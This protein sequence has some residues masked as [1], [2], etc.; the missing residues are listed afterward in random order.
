MQLDA[1]RPGEGFVELAL[2]ASERAHARSF[3][4]LLA[5]TGADIRQGVDPLV[6]KRER[7]LQRLLAAHARYQMEKAGADEP[8]PDQAAL[9]ERLNSLKAEYEELQAQVR[10]E[11][12][13]YQNL[14]RPKALTIS[15]IQAQLGSDDFL[16]E[17]VLGEEQSYLCAVTATSVK[18]YKL[19]QKSKLD[20]AA[21]EVYK[22]LIARQMTGA[23]VD[24]KYQARVEDADNQYYNKALALSRMLLAPVA[25]VLGKKRL[26]IVTEGALQY[27]S[28]DSLPRPTANPVDAKT[29]PEIDESYLISDHEI[30]ILPS[31]SALAAIRA[32]GLTPAHGL[33]AVFA[34]P[35]FTRNDDRVQR[36]ETSTDLA[37]GESN[38]PAFR[39]LSDLNERG[40]L[41]RLTYS[42]DEADNISAAASGNAWIVKGF[43]ATKE[44]VMTE[45]LGQYQIVHFATHGFVNT[46]HPE[47]SMI[48][49]TMIKPD[50]TPVDGFLQL[51]DIFNL[52]L[53]AELTVLSACDTGLGKDVRG[54]GLIGLSRGLMYAGSRSVVASLWKVDDRATAVLMGHFYK[55]LLH[56]RL[57]PAA[58][59]RY[60]KEQ[61]RKEPAWSSPFFWAGFVLQGE[62]DRPITVEQ[63]SRVAPAVIMLAVLAVISG[64]LLFF[65][66][67]YRVRK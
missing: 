22:L 1:Q 63:K 38:S 56:D 60:A 18:G 33:V 37:S 21:L 14:A 23:T 10:N 15:E 2:L 29:A 51:H 8:E 42:S 20:A 16:L 26:L 11:S 32:E 9:E 43:K 34:D 65:R 66:R 50:G 3:L 25:D 54:E 31:I 40:G 52:K 44:N 45:E 67:F 62:Y 7:E 30:V 58:A 5:E 48:V 41:R 47:L 53:S 49:L 12:L 24:E 59:L 6:L 46:E 28:F 36:G 17:F 35:V 61:L 55:A 39:G 4:E 13:R 27:I 64:S 19:E 57:P